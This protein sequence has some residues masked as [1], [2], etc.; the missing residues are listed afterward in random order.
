[1]NRLVIIPDRALELRAP[2][3]A[4]QLATLVDQIRA[5]TL[6]GLIPESDLE[7]LAQ[8]LK[9]LDEDELSIWAP[10]DRGY[11]VVW[12]SREPK[13]EMVG[14][15]SANPEEGLISRIFASGRST[16]ETA[17][18]LQASSWSNIEKRRGQTVS[19]MAGSPVFIASKCA[20]ILAVIQYQASDNRASLA[21]EDLGLLATA[22]S[23]LG[24]LLEDRLIRALIGLKM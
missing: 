5:D 14:S 12:T 6:A 8:T 24:R 7:F 11:S 2:E 4:L 3:I 23:I 18:D 16:R 1:M 17:P 9:V 15:A 13:S 22:A 21:D 10:C 19:S 20:A